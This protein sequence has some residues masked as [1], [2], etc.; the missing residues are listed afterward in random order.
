MGNYHSGL[1]EWERNVEKMVAVSTIYTAIEKEAI[2]I[3]LGFKK[4]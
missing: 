3:E 1:L 2:M 4:S